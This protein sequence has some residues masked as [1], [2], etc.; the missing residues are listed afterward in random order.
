MIDTHAHLYANHFTSDREEM[1]ARAK[2][3][4]VSQIV[5]PNI[6]QESIEGML[7]LEAAHPGFCHAA[8]GLHPGHVHPDTIKTEL[9]TVERWLGQR[10]FCAV[11]EIGLDYYWSKEHVDLQKEA[12]VTQVRWAKELRKPIIIH[13]RDCM[14]DLIELVTQEQDGNLTG[15]FHCFVGTAEHAQKIADLG[16]Y[17]GVG[18]VLT[19]PKGGVAEVVQHVPLDRLVLETDAPYLP[20]VP[21]RGKRNETAYVRYVAEK[22]ATLKEIPL[23]EVVAQTTHNAQKLFAI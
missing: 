21:F 11:G 22:L 10:S 15:V 12:F 8:M 13:A 19:Y 1:L 20:P 17:M 18:G 6:D 23:S 14:D 5:L 7:A 4:G 3:E 2:A 16:M 9:A